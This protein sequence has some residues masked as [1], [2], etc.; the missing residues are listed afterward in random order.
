MIELNIEGVEAIRAEFQRL[1]PD[2]QKHVLNGMAQVAFNTAQQQADTHTKTGALARSLSLKPE[3]DSAW[4]IG[5]DLQHAPHA[6]FVHWGTRP[7]SI[8]PKDKKVLRWPSGQ[9]ANTGF[10]FAR[11]VRHPGYAGDAW[12]VKAADEAVRQFDAIVRRVQG[13][14]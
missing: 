1:V 7:H 4:I 13:A 12:L 10:I 14:V 3:G 2:V 6:L 5:H 11:W 8:R 9:G